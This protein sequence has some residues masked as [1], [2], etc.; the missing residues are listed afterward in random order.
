MKK[1][2]NLLIILILTGSFT[3]TGCSQQTSSSPTP[4]PESTQEMAAEP[5]TPADKPAEQA[6]EELPATG[7]EMEEQT[8]PES[9]DASAESA[10]QTAENPPVINLSD[11]AYASPSN[12]FKVNLPESWNCS[13]SGS[14]QVD[15]HNSG[16]TGMLV[17]RVT[18][19]G[20][21]LVQEDFLSLVHAELVSTYENVK[22]YTQISQDSSDG[23][24]I[25][26]ATWREGDVFWQGIDRFV[27]SGLAVY[28]LRIGSVQEN[29]ESYRPIFDEI[30]QQ[31]ELNSNA[32]ASAPLYTFRK[33]FV[34][35]D[36]IFNLQ[37]PTS[38]SKH[39]D[40][41]SVERSVV[42]GFLS[43]DEYAAVQVV[44][45][46]K[47]SY[48]SPATKATK[49]LQIMHQIYGS[50]MRITVDKVLPD[51]REWLEWYSDRNGIQ[52]TT[53]FDSVSTDLYIFSVIW[54]DSA[55]ELYRPVLEEIIDSFTYEQ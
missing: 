3:L 26:E 52:G 1:T 37:V 51:G 54:Q 53:Y 29:F 39:I 13:E 43:P 2:L 23:A 19:T 8:A 36:Q 25:N 22:A 40:A 44:I 50:D 45:Y 47:G 4:L 14:Y 46:K 6:S 42:E 16:N 34:S 18:N 11:Q 10:E 24:V 12:A 38:W 33:E 9:S 41:V 7:G 17:V 27:R 49:T 5:D 32:M 35:Q 30:I 21:E 48:V 15:C 55:K 28:H 20:Y 31:A